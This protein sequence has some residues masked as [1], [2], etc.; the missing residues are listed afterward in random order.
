MRQ[1]SHPTSWSV[2]QFHDT[3]Q[4]AHRCRQ[5]MTQCWKAT[6]RH[7]TFAVQLSSGH[8]SVL[9]HLSMHSCD[10]HQAMAGIDPA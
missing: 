10:A 2:L 8:N 1:C 5:D 3:P 4:Y 7:R 9:A 6:S